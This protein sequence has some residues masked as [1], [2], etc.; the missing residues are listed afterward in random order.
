MAGGSD[1]RV[2]LDAMSS[3]LGEYGDIKGPQDVITVV[4]YAISETC[5]ISLAIESW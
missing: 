2:L 3:M 1:P 5:N 4:R